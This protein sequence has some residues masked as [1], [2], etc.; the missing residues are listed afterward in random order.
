MTP[1]HTIPA[2]ILDLYRQIKE[3]ER[4]DTS[5]PG[6][7]IVEILTGWFA[8]HGI[9]PGDRPPEPEEP[10][11][12]RRALMVELTAWWELDED[13]LTHALRAAL[14]GFAI[15]VEHAETLDTTWAEI[16]VMDV[17]RS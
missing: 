4:G 17:G 12:Y 9:D 16:Q 15:R 6:S 8:G 1:W 3:A 2:P 11:V 13:D 5:W 14:T 7:D 10:Y